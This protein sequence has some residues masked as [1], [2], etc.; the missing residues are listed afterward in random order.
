MLVC[1]N[2]QPKLWQIQLFKHTDWYRSTFFMSD[3]LG[4]FAYNKVLMSTSAWFEG[5]KNGKSEGLTNIVAKKLKRS[6]LLSSKCKNDCQLAGVFK[7]GKI[8]FLVSVLLLLQ[9]LA[10]RLLEMY[11]SHTMWIFSECFICIQNMFWETCW[12]SRKFIT[13]TP[14]LP[15]VQM[16]QGPL[17]LST[18][19]N[20]T[21]FGWL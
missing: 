14:R 11:S 4:S 3:W 2:F 6:C 7:Q 15:I 19:T 1:S 17:P 20:M 12:R 5:A 13:D 18:S 8:L 10:F 16:Q 9:T 21:F